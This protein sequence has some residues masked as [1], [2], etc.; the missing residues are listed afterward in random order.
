MTRSLP[1]NRPGRRLVYQVGNRSGYRAQS[2]TIC[3]GEKVAPGRGTGSTGAN[4]GPGY[5]L[6][7]PSN[8]DY[9]RS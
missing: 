2:T 5:K 6:V 7:S 8:A 1:P 9:E 3:P 4:S